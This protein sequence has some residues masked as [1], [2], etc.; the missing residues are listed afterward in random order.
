MMQVGA[1]RLLRVW[2]QGVAPDGLV[3]EIGE[4]NRISGL[5][6]AGNGLREAWGGV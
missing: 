5:S 2:V 4:K 1:V 6:R 3:A